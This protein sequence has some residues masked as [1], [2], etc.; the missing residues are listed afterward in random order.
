MKKIVL[1][2]RELREYIKKKIYEDIQGLRDNPK[3]FEAC[4]QDFVKAYDAEGPD[5]K[6]TQKHFFEIV[7]TY[8]QEGLSYLKQSAFNDGHSREML[9]KMN[10]LENVNELYLGL[11]LDSDRRTALIKKYIV[12]S[13]NSGGIDKVS[14]MLK[15]LLNAMLVDF[16]RKG[17]MPKTQTQM[18]IPGAMTRN[19]DNGS[20]A[21]SRSTGGMDYGDNYLNDKIEILNAAIDA[22]HKGKFEFSSK[23]SYYFALALT[24][25][26]DGNEADG[27]SQVRTGPE[28]TM[29]LIKKINEISGK[30]IDKNYF[31]QIKLRFIQ[32]DIPE[33]I[34]RFTAYN[35][36][37]KIAY[38]E[39]KL[40]SI[41][42]E[43]VEN[44]M[45][46]KN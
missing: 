18:E 1:T 36:K 9:G 28:L 20:D 26:V 8:K 42:R 44:I 21:I 10:A 34:R 11:F 23:M 22:A 3:D 25:V 14:N 24:A 31:L 40:R 43:C 46:T 41:I 6:T 38:A 7:A 15:K 33:I 32:K 4:V 13:Y 29:K 2:E 19:I 27:V 17:N 12:D 37:K 30:N 45:K 16:Y 5:G 35:D 39:S